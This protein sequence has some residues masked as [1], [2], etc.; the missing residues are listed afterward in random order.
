MR[1][2]IENYIKIKSPGYSLLIDGPWGSGKTHFIKNDVKDILKQI[3]FKLL[4]V[5]VNGISSTTE[6][7]QQIILRCLHSKTE[8]NRKIIQALKKRAPALLNLVNKADKILSILHPFDFYPPENS[9]YIFDD[10]ERIS[11]EYNIHDFLGFVNSEYIEHSGCRVIFIGD[12]S[13]SQFAGSDFHSIREKYVRWIIPFYSDQ[14]KILDDFVIGFKEDISYFEHLESHKDFIKDL[15][16]R[17][18]VNNLRTIKFFL[19]IYRIIFSKT[20]S[21][22]DLLYKDIIYFTF[23][24]S[25]EY[26]EGRLNLFKDKKQL[27]EIVTHVQKGTTLVYDPFSNRT[28]DLSEIESDKEQLLA[29]FTANFNRYVT[30]GLTSSMQSDIKYSYIPE[31]YDIITTGSW[32]IEKYEMK[33]KDLLRYKRPILINERDK[34]IDNLAYFR[35]VSES[36]LDESVEQVIKA[37]QGNKYNLEEFAR[38]INLLNYLANEKLILITR[39]QVRNLFEDHINHI[40]LGTELNSDFDEASIEYIARELQNLSKDAS[41]KIIDKLKE[42]QH[43]ILVI[44]S[45]RILQNWEYQDDLVASWRSIILHSDTSSIADKLK[46]LARDRNTIQ[47]ITKSIEDAYKST[48]A[49]D[50][51]A[52]H[53]SN[54][55][56]LRE[57]L[58][59]R[60]WTDLDRVDNYF[61]SRLKDQLNKAIGRLGSTKTV[62]NKRS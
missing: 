51:Y 6:L 41:K 39:D 17:F 11:P 60:Q 56:K 62:H 23:I 28:V 9:L 50:Y 8:S 53:T 20:S 44:E 31:I 13:K 27:P 34:N 10:I 19:E 42:R 57:E 5:T 22:F 43:Q 46:E 49:G 16:M 24:M 7:Q 48:N 18:G 32:N 58:R 52:D 54:I 47:K 21:D 38:G 45:S 3:D 33:L 40:T 4:Y 55:S 37:I 30:S 26:Q 1:E 61:I 2:K 29:N 59:R 15:Q 25:I 12:L 14:G 36:D 35:D